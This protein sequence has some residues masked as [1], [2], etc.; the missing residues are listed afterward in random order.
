VHRSID[1]MLSKVDSR[2]TLVILA[3]KRA[4]QI[5][6][7]LNSLKRQELTDIPGPQI[8]QVTQKP[9]TVAFEEIA[10]DKL[11]FERPAE[12]AKKYK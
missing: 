11:G 7:Y 6:D 5:N 9:L 10:E 8:H 4:R 1:K 3:A 12:V 2:F